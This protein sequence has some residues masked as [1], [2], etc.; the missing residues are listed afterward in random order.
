MIVEHATLRSA[1]GVELEASIEWEGTPRGAVVMC[2]A[3]PRMGGT[4]NAPLFL[5]LRDDL[6]ERGWAVLRFNLR[7]V[8]ASTGT[9]GTGLDEVQDA[10]AVIAE[11]RRRW[12]SSAV[13]LIGWSFGGG[14]AVRAAAGD[15]SL[16]AVVA[17]APAVAE[18]PGLTAGLPPGPELGLTQ[19]LLV[20]CGGNDKQVEPV[21]VREWA[22][23]VRGATF[24]EIPGAN[25]FFW[26]VYD[27]LSEVVTDWL[28]HVV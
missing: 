19:P 4:M 12:P 3:H 15:P 10:R 11:A 28:E 25:H 13:T 9:S 5:H 20:V 2:H 23:S 21:E 16:V 6:V 24:V 17:I 27:R 8:G 7:G 18:R 22:R 26:A 14:V 1:P